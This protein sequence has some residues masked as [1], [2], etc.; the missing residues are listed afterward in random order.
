MQWLPQ[1][2]T[3]Y[4]NWLI[5]TAQLSYIHYPILGLGIRYFAEANEQNKV[6]FGAEAIA[7]LICSTDV[8][9]IDVKNVDPKNK[10]NDKKRVFRVFY[11]KNKKR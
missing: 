5:M 8:Q 7:L 11:L 1:S 10:K 4:N 2:V 9:T 6:W 3:G